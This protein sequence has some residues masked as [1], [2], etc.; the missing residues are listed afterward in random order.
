MKRNGLIAVCV[1]TLAAWPAWAAPTV[2]YGPDGMDDGGDW[3]MATGGDGDVAA[4]FGYDYSADGIPSAPNG[5]DTLGVKLEANLVDPAAAAFFTLSPDLFTVS[6]T[7]QLRFDAW[8]NLDADERAAGGFGTTEFQ[9]GGVGYDGVTAD[10]AS[11][12]QAM[13]TS[14][15]GSSNDWRAF[16]S[17]PQFFIP[18]AD[19]AAGTHQ[20]SDAYYA[21]FLPSVLPPVAQGQSGLNGSVAGSPGLQWITWVFTSINRGPI[22]RVIVDIEKPAHTD[23]E[24]KP[25]WALFQVGTARLWFDTVIGEGSR[26]TA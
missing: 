5:G 15:G 23:F 22:N 13:A 20:G 3:N 17:P 2:L 18:D 7:H 19:M 24:V 8:A 21:D 26:Y 14:E 16:K 25:Y 1:L 11:G 9:G 4:T 6:G 12:T 10:I